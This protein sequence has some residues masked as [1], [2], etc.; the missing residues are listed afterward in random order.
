MAFL[1]TNITKLTKTKQKTLETNNNQEW[2]KGSRV[3]EGFITTAITLEFILDLVLSS[4]AGS[5]PKVL[6]G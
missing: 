3:K 5:T 2:M 1:V 4:L 6:H